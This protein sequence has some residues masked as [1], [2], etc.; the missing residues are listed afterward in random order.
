MEEKEIWLCRVF[1]VLVMDKKHEIG[2]RGQTLPSVPDS[3]FYHLPEYKRFSA[4]E[5]FLAIK[6][7]CHLRQSHLMYIRTQSSILSHDG[8]HCGGAASINLL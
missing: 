3:V 1:S 6:T 2:D 4:S 8:H 5:G 7:H